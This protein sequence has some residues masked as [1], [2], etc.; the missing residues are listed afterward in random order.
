[1]IDIFKDANSSASEDDSE[2]S[3][4]AKVAKQKSNTLKFVIAIN[5]LFFLLFN[6]SYF[7]IT[8]F[9]FGNNSLYKNCNL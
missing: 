8:L 4:D 6:Y 7:L 3:D 2:G 1:M 9:Q 5:Y